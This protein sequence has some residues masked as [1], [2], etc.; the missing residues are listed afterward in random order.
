MKRD[1]ESERVVAALVR[2]IDLERER[3]EVTA[4]QEIRSHRGCI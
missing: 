3:T 2:S 1:L 4:V